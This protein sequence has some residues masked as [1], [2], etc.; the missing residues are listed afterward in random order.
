M[1]DEYLMILNS[2]EL[3]RLMLYLHILLNVTHDISNGKVPIIKRLLE[4]RT[5]RS[6]FKK[7]DANKFIPSGTSAALQLLIVI[8]TCFLF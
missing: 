7:L 2:L 1:E 6:G 4:C 8:R 3:L 5:T